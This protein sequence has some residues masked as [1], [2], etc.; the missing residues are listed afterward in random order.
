MSSFL[1]K[2]L[3]SND[4]KF[5]PGFPPTRSAF[6]G[7][8]SMKEESVPR[9]PT[10]T[11]R[12]HS[13]NPWCSQQRWCAPYCLSQPVPSLSYSR[14]VSQYFLVQRRQRP[15]LR[16]SDSMR[17]RIRW[18]LCCGRRQRVIQVLG[19]CNEAARVTASGHQQQYLTAHHKRCT[20]QTIPDCNNKT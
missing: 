13:K 17:C 15:L 9:S 7:V 16:K 8:G 10:N 20:N 3:R 1:P 14:A 5:V 6:K 18:S 2:R 4:E 19:E 11:T 12:T